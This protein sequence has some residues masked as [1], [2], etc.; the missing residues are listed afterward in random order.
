MI[1]WFLSGG[2]IMWPL[3]VLALGVIGLA[4]RAALELR[5][6]AAQ[7]EEPATAPAR[8]PA[9]ATI[10]FWG[11]VALLVGALGTV[12]GIVIMSRNVAAAGGVSGTLAWGGVGVSLVSLVFGILIF[13]VAGFLWLPLDAWSRSVS[14][15]RSGTG[16]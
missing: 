16:D 15:R 1:D 2:I 3:L 7:P 5:R 11:G 13:L 8:R 10:L 14:A 9:L 12:V 6:A 4:V